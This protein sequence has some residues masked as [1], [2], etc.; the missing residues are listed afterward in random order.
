MANE[1]PGTVSNDK[2]IQ[3]REEKHTDAPERSIDQP[4]NPSPKLQEKQQRNNTVE[5]RQTRPSNQ[6]NFPRGNCS[7][8]F[9]SEEKLVQHFVAAHGKPRSPPYKKA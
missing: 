7:T 9:N 1:L 2:S 8:R 4:R 5:P 3:K 6:L